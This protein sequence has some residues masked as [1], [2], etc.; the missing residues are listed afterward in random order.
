V[1]ALAAIA[2]CGCNQIYGLTETRPELFDAPA[3]APFTCPGSG[4]PVFKQDPHQV[5]AMNCRSYTTAAAA[6]LATADCDGG[7][8]W[9]T[10]QNVYIVFPIDTDPS[11]STAT[12]LTQASSFASTLID[13]EGDQVFITY[14]PPTSGLVLVSYSSSGGSW[15]QGASPLLPTSFDNNDRISNPSRRPDRRLLYFH[16]IDQSWHEVTEASAGTW[17]EVRT[18]PEL[19]GSADN[20]RLSADGLRVTASRYP[21]GGAFNAPMYASRSSL[22]ASFTPFVQI[23]TVPESA[24]YPFLS[25]D[26]G[27]LYFSGVSSVFFAQQQ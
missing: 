8:A 27:R 11:P 18:H 6:G 22:D 7:G 25:D 26:C 13:P 21:S 24:A 3:D 15:S 2:L 16:A 23:T 1:R 20:P 9:G 17:T 12:V 19:G 5:T 14:Y 10:T 4:V